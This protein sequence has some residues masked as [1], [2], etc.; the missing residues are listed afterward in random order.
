MVSTPTEI[1][2]IQLIICAYENEIDGL[3]AAGKILMQKSSTLFKK[4]K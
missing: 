3:E 4:M 1:S 2:R